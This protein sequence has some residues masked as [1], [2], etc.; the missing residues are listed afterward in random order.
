MLLAVIIK[1]S[2]RRIGKR[3]PVQPEMYGIAHS[4]FL[5]GSGQI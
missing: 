2:I 3:F 5:L 4:K 1:S